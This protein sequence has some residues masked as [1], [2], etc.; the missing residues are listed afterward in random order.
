[1]LNPTHNHKAVTSLVLRNLSVRA[2][3]NHQAVTSNYK[4]EFPVQLDLTLVTL[5]CRADI[6]I[7]TPVTLRCK[8]D[9]Q[10]KTVNQIHQ[11]P[12]L[13]CKV[14]TKMKR[15]HVQKDLL[16]PILNYKPDTQMKRALARKDHLTAQT[17][18]CRA[19]IAKKAVKRSSLIAL[20]VSSTT[21]EIV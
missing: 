4:K 2:N 21:T 9:T 16:V 6:L 18:K 15:A 19:V 13:R 14:V 7:V 5:K 11:A 8:V 12:I 20:T 1:M 17:L 10:M 3:M